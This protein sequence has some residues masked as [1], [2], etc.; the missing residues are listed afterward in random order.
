VRL[1][2][3]WSGLRYGGKASAGMAGNNVDPLAFDTGGD[4]IFFFTIF[5]GGLAIF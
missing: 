1:T 4:F 5:F 2:G 3:G